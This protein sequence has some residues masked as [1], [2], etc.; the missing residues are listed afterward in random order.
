MDLND[1]TCFLCGEPLDDRRTREHVFPKWLQHRHDLWSK[2]LTLLNGT[3]ISYSQLTIPC[4][5]SC[6]NDHLGKLENTVRQAIHGG[7]AAA[8]ELPPLTIYQWL[9][10]IFFGILRKELRLLLNRR[11][12]SE[13]TIVQDDLLERFATLHV[14]LQSIRQPFQFVGAM[15]FSTLV[16]N[17]H[18]RDSQDDYFFRDSLPLTVASLRTKEV[19]FIVALQDAGIIRETYGKYVDAVAG[20]KLMPIQFDELYAKTLYQVALLNRTPKFV[21]GTN[22]DPTIPTTVHML[23]IGGLSSKPVADDWIQADFV[24]ILEP[25]VQ[26]SFP[27]VTRDELFVPPDHVMTWMNDQNGV[28]TL[29]DENGNR[30]P[31]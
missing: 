20:R 8:A 23:P 18:N 13:G 10:K 11:D 26:Q 12:P 15:P 22:M 7:Y 29:V 21:T 24:D 9:G 2:E 17:L 27:N 6:N 16:V 14:F 28:L 4:C 3:H 31:P 1:D 30:I 25:I 19:G 5:D